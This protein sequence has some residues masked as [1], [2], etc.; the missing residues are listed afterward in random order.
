MQAR[1]TAVSTANTD[2]VICPVDKY[3]LS[4]YDVIRPVLGTRVIVLSCLHGACSLVKDVDNTP[5]ILH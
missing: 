5:A 4:T 2:S 1:E 3:L